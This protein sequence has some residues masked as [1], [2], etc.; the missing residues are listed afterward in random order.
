M[1]QIKGGFHILQADLF[2]VRD[3]YQDVRFANNPL[4]TTDPKIRFY[5]GAPLITPDGLA[6]GTLC[7]M[8]IV[9]RDLTEQQQEALQ[10]LAR[11]VMTQ[12]ELRRNLPALKRA[13]TQQ[14]QV[15]AALEQARDEL[16]IK[17]EERT[18]ELRKTNEQLQSEIVERQRAE[19]ELRFL[20]TMTQAISESPDFHSALGVALRYVCE[21]TGWNFGEAWIPDPN[22]TTL[23]AAGACLVIKASRVDSGC[24]KCTIQRFAGS[25]IRESSWF[26]S[27]VRSP[28]Y[29]FPHGGREP[30]GTGCSRFFHV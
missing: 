16:E 12:L 23:E 4:V 20:Q 26:Q 30:G 27:W 6:L 17:V 11:Q 18:V 1:V 13:I 10:I 24:F 3:A 14:Q 15:E 22:G 21:V 8:D 9:P 7:I 29:C 5:A 2:I 25:P 28:D 19:E